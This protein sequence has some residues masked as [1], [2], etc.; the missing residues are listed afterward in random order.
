MHCKQWLLAALMTFSVS[1]GGLVAADTSKK[2]D[3]Q[4]TISETQF[5]FIIGGSVGDGELIV[6]GKKMPFKIGGLG[7]GVNFGI[8]KM[9]ASGDVYDMKKVEDFPGNYARASGNL[10][11][12]KG[13][14]GMTLQN[15]KGVVLQ[16][17]G[18]TEGLQF[19]V[20]AGGVNIYFPK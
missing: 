1:F 14:G 11:V 19:D 15:E 9:S 18:S 8:S 5:G 7:L 17:N 20:S 12:G 16:L 10:T 13:V 6:D 4:I 2:P 3:A